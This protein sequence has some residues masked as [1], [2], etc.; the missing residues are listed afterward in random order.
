[1]GMRRY[2][3]GTPRPGWSAWLDAQDGL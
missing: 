2:A 3:D 1:M